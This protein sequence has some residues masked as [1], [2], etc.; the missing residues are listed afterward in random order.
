MKITGPKGVPII[1]SFMFLAAAAVNAATYTASTLSPVEIQGLI[2]GA[3]DGDTVQLPVGVSTWTSGITITDKN[4]TLM[5]AGIDQTNIIDDTDATAT[6]ITVPGTAGKGFRI[7]GITITGADWT[8]VDAGNPALININGSYNNW[9]ID[10]VK[11]IGRING[12]IKINGFNPTG[13]ID[14]CTFYIKHHGGS[15][16][17]YAIWNQDNGSDQGNT[18]WTRP[19]ALGTSNAL[20]IEDCL[21]EFIL[22]VSGNIVFLHTEGGARTVVRNSKTNAVEEHWSA[23]ATGGN[24]GTIYL[25]IYNNIFGGAYAKADRALAL[26]GATGVFYNNQLFSGV[27]NTTAF[28]IQHHRSDGLYYQMVNGIYVNDTKCNGTAFIDGNLPV[29][30]DWATFTGSHSGGNGDSTLACAGRSW[31]PGALVGKTVWNMTGYSRGTITANTA[32]TI[33]SVPFVIKES[34]YN[35]AA[36]MSEGYIIIDTGTHTGADNASA[37]ACSPRYWTSWKLAYWHVYNVTDG[38]RAKITSAVPVSG[39]P[40]TGLNAPLSGGTD[41]N[42]DTGDVFQVCVDYPRTNSRNFWNTGDNF[43][44]TDGWPCLDQLGRGPGTELVNGTTVQKSEPFYEWNNTLNGN[45]TNF[46]SR[47]LSALSMSHLKSGRDYY[48]GIVKPGY[49]SFT[50]PHPLTLSGITD[51][52]PP[53]APVIVRDGTNPSANWSFTYST[54]SLSANWDVCTDTETGISAYYVAI[55]TGPGLINTAAW[56]SVG[57]S[58][59]VTLINLTLTTGVTYYYSVRSQDG[60][61]QLSTITSSD[62]QYVAPDGTP[63]SD[64][65]IVRDGTGADVAFTYSTNT[66]SAN[67]AS[68]AD[69]ESGISKYW[70]SIG[71]SAGAQDI[72]AWTNVWE[73]TSVTR[74]GLVLSFNTTYY[75]TVYAQNSVGLVCS[76][77]SSNGQYAAQDLT[78]PSAPVV[79]RDGTGASDWSFAYSTTGL[80]ANWDAC[81]DAE[82]GIG[83]YMYAISSTT[84]GGTGFVA[85]TDNG[86]STYVTHR[87]LVLAHGVT[88]YFSVRAENPFG[89]ASAAVN[90]NGQYIAV[91]TSPPSNIAAVRDGAAGADVSF[92]YSTT[93]LSANW[94]RSIDTE[95]GISRYYYAVSS[96]AAGGYEFIGWT[97]VWTSTYVTRSSLAL[98]VGT[99]YYFAVKAENGVGYQTAVV[100]SNGQYVAPDPTPPS[101]PATVRDGTGSFDWYFTYSSV[102]LSA[103]WDASVDGESGIAKYWYAMGTTAGGIDVAAWASTQATSATINGLALNIGSTYYFTVKAENGVGGQSAAINSNG[104]YIVENWSTP[105]YPVISGLAAVNIT[106]TSAVINWTTDR[107]ATS[108]VEYGRTTNYGTLTIE[109]SNLVTGHSVSLT[110]LISGTRYHYRVITREGSGF[111]TISAGGIFTTQSDEPQINADIHVYPNPCKISAANP[112]RFRM[113][114]NPCAEASIY[115]VSGRLIRKITPAS[116]SAEVTWDGTNADGQKTGRGI[117]IFKITGSSGDTVTGKLALTR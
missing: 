9:R 97:N 27:F 22:D 88:Y 23:G 111:E 46:F 25:E 7:T 33:T 24:R 35:P 14:H 15:G 58:T 90:S 113:A 112:A 20:Y 115:T 102:T 42:W 48:S 75:F 32:D 73:A 29:D 101:S 68:S 10:H 95:S 3:S 8:A 98:L 87:N 100:N 81:A 85:W 37:L 103:N 108:Q 38:S 105:P 94:D 93:T 52:T 74:T 44:V 26:D 13:L 76:T 59:N 2:N 106:K 65:S 30:N 12:G 63:P 39:S 49:A 114:G 117:Y 57:L 17:T 47:N 5:G 92:T 40:I 61:N 107:S 28:N 72:A 82:T 67:W 45:T 21:F 116:P 36:P 86:V 62:G 104:Q 77:I 1:F 51:V 71:A 83:R 16:A 34:S 110:G 64:I 55:G 91:D 6:I 54:R 66:L 69:A 43:K 18:A 109:D 79:I 70:Y 50:Y 4:I 19:L 53:T 99:T 56:Q 78:P 89:L 41:N 60:V 11:M 96:T 84:A 31:T 80:S